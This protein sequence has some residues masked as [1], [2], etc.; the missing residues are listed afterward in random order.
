MCRLSAIC[1]HFVRER[2][3]IRPYQALH[4]STKQGPKT[5]PDQH[6]RQLYGMRHYATGMSSSPPSDTPQVHAVAELGRMA[7]ARR[8]CGISLIP[9]STWR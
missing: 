3:R 7:T 8:R 6:E 2:P 4:R 5:A 1:H 9:S